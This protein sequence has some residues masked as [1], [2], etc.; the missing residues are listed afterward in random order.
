MRAQV[1]QVA[2]LFARVDSV[3]KKLPGCDVF[4][5][6]RDA[7]TWQG[8]VPAVA[9]PPCRAWGR[10]KTFA[11]PRADEK[12]L[13]LFAFEQVRKFG[14]VLEH[15]AYSELF[16]ACGCATPGKKDEFG[17]Y[18]LPIMQS[19]F[20]HRAPKSTWIYV[21]GCSAGNLPVMPMHLGMAAGRVEN[22][23]RREREATPEP[24]A[25]WLCEV[26]RLCA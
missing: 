14:G 9:H 12:A 6:D 26:A 21:M 1:R 2:V 15:P 4:D 7:R 13:G 22:M 5:I 16:K 11:K 25:R 8:G 3:Y 19:W 10:L 18:I 20:G 17:G 24:L 23:G